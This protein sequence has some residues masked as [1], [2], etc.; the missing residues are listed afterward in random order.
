MKNTENNKQK[1]SSLHLRGASGAQ[2]ILSLRSAVLAAR[3]ALILPVAKRHDDKCDG[4]L[5]PE[6][7]A[8]A[9]CFLSAV[10]KRGTQAKKAQ[11]D[12]LQYNED[13]Q[14]LNCV[15]DTQ[16]FLNDVYNERYMSEKITSRCLQVGRSMIEMLGVLA[17]IG[18]L[19]VGGIAGYSKAMH[20]YR[21]NKTIDQITYMA[22]AIRT[23]FAPQKS[24]DGLDSET[25]PEV[26]K[27]AKLVPDDMWVE[28]ENE[29][30]NMWGNYVN[31]GTTCRTLA[32]CN[33]RIHKAFYIGYNNIPEE[34]CIDLLTQDWSNAGVGM[35]YVLSYENAEAALQGEEL[36]VIPPVSVDK[37]I[38]L[39]STSADDEGRVDYID[40]DFDVDVNDSMWKDQIDATTA[41]LNGD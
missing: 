12:A 22:G 25:N 28:G 32:E 15:A 7:G 16:L 41:L 31:V 21:V 14:R 3:D 34:A 18:V 40:F 38:R 30:Q 24:Y 11:A 39:C 8:D 9:T 10:Y 37:A 29:P 20:R 35:F 4:R 23:F 5:R 17:I 13:K 36:Y 27:K 26:I 1:R 6:C 33:N 2:G 19:S